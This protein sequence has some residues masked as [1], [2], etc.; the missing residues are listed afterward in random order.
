MT[1]ILSYF[2]P[3]LKPR[4]SQEIVIK[5]ID[6]VFKEG[7]RIIILEAPVGSGKSAIAMTLAKAQGKAGAHLITPRKSLQEQYYHDFKENLVLMKGRNS[8][9]CTIDA[10]PGAYES[11]IQAVE[12]GMVR[13]PARGVQSCSDAPCKDN[14]PIYDE[15]TKNRDRVCPYKAAIEVAQNSD[16][17]VHN[18]HSFIFQVNFSEQFQKRGIMIIDEAHE[19]ENTVREFIIKKLMIRR[20]IT[21]QQLAAITTTKQLVDFLMNPD[22]VPVESDAEKEKKAVDKM[23]RS[24]RDEYLGKLETMTV[25]EET[26]DKGFSLEVTPILKEDRQVATSI[27]VIPHKLGNTVEELLLQYGEKVLLMSGTIYNKESFCRNLGVDPSQAHFIRIGSSFPK[28]NRPIYA[29]TAYQVDT[30]HRNWTDNFDE[31]I[32]KIKSVMTIFENAKGLIHAPSYRAAVEIVNELKDPR[33]VTHTA[34]DF[35][36]KLDE[37]FASK[38]NQVLVSPTCQQGVDFKGDRARF[39]IIIRVPYT[40]TS[41]KFVEDKVKGDFPWYNYQALVTFG[42]Q[43]GR[44]NRSEDDYGATFLLDSRFQ[45][46]ISKNRKVLPSWVNEAIHY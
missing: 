28:E 38:G 8:Y 37:F 1:D 24:D 29:K 15:C 42:Q 31:M 22:F 45:A 33:V 44:V 7:K 40:S 2:P 23:Y 13:Q 9:P 41:S 12:R 25:Y 14:K 36:T 18:L 39:Q 27:E 17:I 20:V 19:V 11:V 46:F 35:L 3:A 30:S 16:I 4:R 21:A 32:Q 43:I 26:L 6:K 5:E 34:Q 10:S